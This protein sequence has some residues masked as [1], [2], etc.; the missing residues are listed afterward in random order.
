MWPFPANSCVHEQIHYLT[1]AEVDAL[2]MA[3]DRTTWSG[4]RD[5]AWLLLAVQTGLRLSEL[6]VLNRADVQLGA[7]AHVSMIGE[8]CK[9]R[10][11]PMTKQTSSCDEVWLK[12]PTRGD[13]TDRFS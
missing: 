13:W 3:P 1:R 4:R 5:Q 12:E 6:T 10:C 9:E 11:T 8:A 7:G 2:L